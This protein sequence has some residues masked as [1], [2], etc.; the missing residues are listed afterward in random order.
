MGFT[1]LTL[2]S[3]QFATAPVYAE[4][5]KPT[6][7]SNNE[8][9]PSQEETASKVLNLYEGSWDSEKTVKKT[10]WIKEKLKESE[11]KSA[12]WTLNDKYLEILSQG[13][14]Q[15]TKEV[16][17][18]NEQSKD[19]QK[20]IFDTNGNTSYWTGK[21]DEPSK[22]MTWTLNFDVIKGIIID[23]F[24]ADAKPDEYKT[25]YSTFILTDKN[26]CLLLDISAKNTK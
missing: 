1:L 13:E 9:P 2:T 20:F 16:N 15:T 7:E 10:S 14:K 12:Q 5:V 3:I 21:W 23:R 19:F 11:K 17:C 26:G 4:E 25:W 18:F 24:V 22:T 6:A 8:K